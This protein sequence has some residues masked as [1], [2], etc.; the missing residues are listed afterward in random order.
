MFGKCRRSRRKVRKW[1]GTGE[2]KGVAFSRWIRES[3]GFEG[4]LG[5]RAS[6]F[7]EQ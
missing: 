3:N 5:A 1:G 6:D 7:L 2:I 4:L